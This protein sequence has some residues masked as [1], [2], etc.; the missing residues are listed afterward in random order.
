MRYLKNICILFLLSGC[1]TFVSEHPA[2]G[3]WSRCEKDGSYWEYKITNQYTIIVN[4]LYDE[5]RFIRNQIVDTNLVISEFK[6]ELGLLDNTERVIISEQ[7]NNRIV[8]KSIVTCSSV[9]LNKKE[10]DF[11]PIDS[12]HLEVWK[13]KVLADFKKRAALMDC[14]DVRTE[15]EKIIPFLKLD[16]S[17]EEI[18]IIEIDN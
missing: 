18:Q 3:S 7:S 16:D 2:I 13:S 12:L 8:F 5:V 14:P 1:Q 17:E 6:N 4:T 9:E 15:E 11:D 10:F